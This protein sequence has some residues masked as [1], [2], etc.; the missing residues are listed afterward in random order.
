MSTSYTQNVDSDF[1]DACRKLLQQMDNEAESGDGTKYSVVLPVH[2]EQEN[3]GE[4]NR[5]L[6]EVLRSRGEAFEIIYV[7]D[8]SRDGSLALL[9]QFVA[10]S[11]EVR[12][13]DL[14]RNFGHQIAIS[15]GIAHARGKAVIV[16]DSDLQDPPEVLPEFIAEWEKGNDVVYA[17]REKRKESLL[18][19]GCY[20]LFYRMLQR[21]ANIEIPLDSGDFCIMDRKVVELLN[22]MPERNRFVRGIRSWVGLKQKGLTYERHARYAGKPTYNFRRLMV[23][24]L[25]GFISFSHAPLRVAALLGLIV[26]VVSLL[27]TVI[28]VVQKFTTGLEPPGF[29]SIITALFFFSGV[30]LLTLG[31]IGE[32]IGRI[33]DE[34]KQR[35][36]YV[37]REVLGDGN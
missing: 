11:T 35:P 12:V 27:M 7:N 8:G 25:D 5:R 26:S 22:A 18:K 30:N 21:V 13:V 37:V 28:F 3:L 31:V 32:Y 19:R 36:L 15:A 2:N 33:F 16:M 24:A 10:E 9:S 14:A 6:F 17:V 4:L 23:L 1:I 20:S 34:V 29:A